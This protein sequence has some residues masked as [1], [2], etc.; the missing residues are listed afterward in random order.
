VQRK[1]DDAPSPQQPQGAHV[2]RLIQL[3]AAPAAATAGRDDAHTLLSSLGIP[4]L[5]AVMEGVADCGYLSQLHARVSSWTNPFTAAR[6]LSALYA[7]ELVRMPQAAV[8]TGQLKAAGLALDAL[9]VRA[10]PTNDPRVR[11]LGSVLGRHI[12]ES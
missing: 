2:D 5:L 12:L 9:P 8:A 7:I 3:L 6:L 10:Q 11:G 1:P 4:E